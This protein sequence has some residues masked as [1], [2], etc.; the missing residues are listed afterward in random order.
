MLKKEY[1]LSLTTQGPTYPPSEVMDA[2]GNF[3]VIGRLNLESDEGALCQEWGAAIV[4]S[5]S[6]TPKFGEN[7]PYNI[8]KLLDLNN[9]C[10]DANK[11]LYTLPLPL[12][13]NNYP[14]IFAPSQT[15]AFVNKRESYPLHLAPIP[16]ER[17]LDGRKLKEPIT[18]AQWVKAKGHLCVEVENGNLEA[19]FSFRFKSLIPN[20]LYTVMALRELDLNPISP[21]RPGPL[22]IPN[23]FI[24]DQEG[25]ATYRVTMP[26]PFEAK[27]IKGRNRIVNVV[28]L[29]MSTQMSYG[30]A[31]GHY[32]L[33][34]DIHAQLKLQVPSFM[35]FNTSNQN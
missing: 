4:G 27:A 26:N 9:L 28:V 16:D 24:T 31:I 10:D 34:G 25:N 23:V 33:G 8:I 17:K 32:G 1:E 20:S 11:V 13:C 18:L 19:V 2:D 12:P 7:V 22:G 15:P 6:I 35:E 30:G 14:M 21:S 3:I 29:W 5:D